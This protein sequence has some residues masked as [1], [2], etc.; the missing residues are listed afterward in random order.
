[1][2]LFSQCKR[3]SLSASQVEPTSWLSHEHISKDKAIAHTTHII[4]FIIFNVFNI[5]IILII[6]NLLPFCHFCHFQSFLLKK[7]RCPSTP[8][9]CKSIRTPSRPKS[10]TRPNWMINAAGSSRLLPR[11]QPWRVKQEARSS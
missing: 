2:D 9:T 6:F 8:Y 3:H 10:D 4:S 1:V 5:F 7:S 11:P